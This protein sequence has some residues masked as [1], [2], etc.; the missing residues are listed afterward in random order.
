M[1]LEQARA[2]FGPGQALALGPTR[3]GNWFGAGESG[4][5]M[6]TRWGRCAPQTVT[7]KGHGAYPGDY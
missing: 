3:D 6:K 4:P 7:D 5:R 2:A 1:L